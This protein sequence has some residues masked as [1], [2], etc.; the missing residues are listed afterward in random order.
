MLRLH[1]Y[2]CTISLQCPQWP[3][4]DFGQPKARVKDGWESSRGF[5]ESDKAASAHM[6][7]YLS[8]SSLWPLLPFIKAGFLNRNGTSEALYIDMPHTDPCCHHPQK[9]LTPPRLTPLSKEQQQSPCVD[10]LS[11]HSDSLRKQFVQAWVYRCAAQ[12]L[13]HWATDQRFRH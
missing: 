10:F 11:T 5:Q 7:I 13:R 8:S 4:E 1:G 6:L 2:M 3:K 12:V 9:T